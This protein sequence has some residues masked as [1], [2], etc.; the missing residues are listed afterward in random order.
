MLKKHDDFDK[1]IAAQEEKFHLLNRETK[2]SNAPYIHLTQ[3]L[4]WPTAPPKNGSS[5]FY[6]QFLS[7]LNDGF[8]C[9]QLQED[10][11]HTLS[12]RYGTQQT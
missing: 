3:L 11:Q 7:S 8:G 2:V 5:Y 6:W 10:S 9:Y 12:P 1:V 4:K